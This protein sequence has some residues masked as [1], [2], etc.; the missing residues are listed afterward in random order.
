MQLPIETKTIQIEIVEFCEM[1]NSN[2]LSSQVLMR[3]VVAVSGEKSGR[4]SKVIALILYLDLK[5]FK[6]DMQQTQHKGETI[7]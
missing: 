3:A 4:N 5:L 1:G 7:I 6:S 2:G